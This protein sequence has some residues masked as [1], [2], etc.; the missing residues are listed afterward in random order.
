MF[1]VRLL[2][3]SNLQAFT[4]RS[5]STTSIGR[6]QLL[7]LRPNK[8]ISVLKRCYQT[9]TNAWRTWEAVEK[10]RGITG[11]DMLIPSVCMALQPLLSFQFFD[12][13]Y[14]TYVFS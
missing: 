10:P 6:S 7:C 8:D 4:V 9:K 11:D 1:A 14:L 13:Y 3:K 5:F 12:S 2:S